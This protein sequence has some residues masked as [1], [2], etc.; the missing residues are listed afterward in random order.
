MSGIE[1]AGLVLGALPILFQAIDFYKDGFGK[2]L[3][4]IRKRK[5]VEKLSRAV[6]MQKQILEELVR[7]IVGASGCENIVQLDDDPLGYLKD[8]YIR[9]QVQDYLGKRNV[10]AFNDALEE[11]NAIVKRLSS[12]IAGL[13]PDFKGP[14]DDLLEIITA[15][16]ESPHGRLDLVPRIK[17]LFRLDELKDFVHELDDATNRLS[18]FARIVLSN[19]QVGN[20][21]P[22]PK[23][24][25]LA[26]ALRQVRDLASSLHVALCQGWK[27]GCHA[28]HGAKLFLDD[29]IGT[30]AQ[31]LQSCGRRTLI[32]TLDFNII[33]VA[34]SDKG[35]FSWNETSVQVYR[36]ELHQS[37]KPSS[38]SKVQII[39]SQEEA[40]VKPEITLFGDIC[41]AIETARCAQ[42]PIVF[43]LTE[44]HQVGMTSGKEASIAHSESD[45]ISLKALLLSTDSQRHIPI[46]PLKFRMFIALTLSSNMLQLLQT[47]WLEDAWSKEKVYFLSKKRDSSKQHVDLSRPFV[48]LT[49]D[50]K[51]RNASKVRVE[52]KIALLEL[53]ILL[54]EIWYETCLETWFSLDEAPAGYYE[55]LALAEEWLD[56]TRNPLPELYEKAVSHCIRRTVGGEFRLLEWEDMKFWEA[57]CEDIIEPLSTICKQWH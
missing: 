25:K 27:T 6:H 49:F 42:S 8:E 28:E 39:T 11:S 45:S 14:T 57:I 12:S 2:S 9:E 37:N 15:N 1:V 5:Y 7:S 52:P 31:I 48:S 16:R 30:V 22:S 21:R 51:S 40:F 23:A 53:G 26:K 56:D 33:F 34:T 29:R 32:P 19:R 50:A 36:N 4:V 38:T 47:Q 35:Q 55:R 44:E 24:T 18:I 3:R 43:I 17:L 46:L 10:D 20:D 41:G 13:V 54:L